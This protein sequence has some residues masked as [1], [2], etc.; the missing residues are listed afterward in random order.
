MLNCCNIC[1]KICRCVLLGPKEGKAFQIPLVEP[2]LPCVIPTLGGI[3]FVNAARCVRFFI[4]FFSK[5][6]YTPTLSVVS[7]LCISALWVCRFV[8]RQGKKV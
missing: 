2:F 5:K 8:C 4:F 7:M 1:S 6:T 3:S